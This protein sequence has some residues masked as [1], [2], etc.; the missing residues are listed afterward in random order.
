M[1][2]K[3][4]EV[5]IVINEE[6]DKNLKENHSKFSEQN[7]DDTDLNDWKSKINGVNTF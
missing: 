3:N 6:G 5:F 2:R 1:R 4:K 7:H